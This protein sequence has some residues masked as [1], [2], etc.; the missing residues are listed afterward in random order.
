MK[1]IFA[2]LLCMLM[3][4]S[5]LPVSAFAEGSYRISISGGT[6]DQS[7][8]EEGAVVTLTAAVPE[9]KTFK[10]WTSSPAVSFSDS[11]AASATF[12]MPCQASPDRRKPP[13]LC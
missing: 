8:A 12:S 6:A 4:V 13:L 10:E 7:T 2:M 1:R 9:N 3:C 11:K 5:L